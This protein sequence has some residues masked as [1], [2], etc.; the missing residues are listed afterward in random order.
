MRRVPQTTNVAAEELPVKNSRIKGTL[1][2]VLHAKAHP[3]PLVKTLFMTITMNT[4]RILAFS[5]GKIPY[6]ISD[7]LNDKVD[8]CVVSL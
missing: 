2:C 6:S 3:Y 4:E 7:W 5:I 1:M 8:S